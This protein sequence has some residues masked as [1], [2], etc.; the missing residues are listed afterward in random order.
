[1]ATGI[2]LLDEASC[3]VENFYSCGRT[4]LSIFF[5][6][7]SGV[8]GC[9]M[10]PW[11]TAPLKCQAELS[12]ILLV[13]WAFAIA[14]LTFG[15]GPAV[16]IN[17]MYLGIF[18][19]F[20]LS[21]N[22][23]STTLYADS[24]LDAS[25]HSQVEF[26]RRES[27]AENEFLGAA[28]ILD[29]A[30]ANITRVSTDEDPNNDPRRFDES[31]AILFESVGGSISSLDNQLTSPR[32][33]AAS[34]FNRKVV[35]GKREF[36]RVEIWF[37]LFV[38]SS[39]CLS[40]FVDEINSCESLVRQW[41]VVTP[42]LSVLISL[43]GWFTS[44]IKK[45]W[46]YYSEGALILIC[47]LFWM[48]GLVAVTRYYLNAEIMTDECAQD[49]AG[50][51]RL[52]AN[53]LF[54]SY[55]SFFTSLYLM[56]EW[57]DASTTTTDWIFLTAASGTIFGV[58]YIG[59]PD[60]F[61]RCNVD[62]F[63]SGTTV[64]DVCT[65]LEIKLVVALSLGSALI[66]FVMVLVSFISCC[67]VKLVPIVH[68]IIGFTLLSLWC[69]GSYFIVFEQEGVGSEI[70]P[71]FFNC[72][73]SLFFCV[74]IATTNL[75]LVFR[76]ETGEHDDESLGSLQEGLENYEDEEGNTDTNNA[77][78][79]KFF[80]ERPVGANSPLSII[81]DGSSSRIEYSDHSAPEVQRNISFEST[82]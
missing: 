5:G 50:E 20:F 38:Q 8:A 61:R 54:M 37:W 31:T 58:L 62:N 63:D 15:D 36:S 19:C 70:G 13:T 64:N 53:Q 30:Y 78:R 71:T 42:A 34:V 18:F 32:S 1:M 25:P 65:D 52:T 81:I 14:I 26:G 73:L 2:S 56:T 80:D 59:H 77:V 22:I 43:I 28:G 72:W 17:T 47:I 55:G 4:F 41:I 10:I 66:S 16:F 12:L 44:S 45:K 51:R 39:V 49:Y 11:R 9:L 46:A 33:Q 82:D 23:F 74:D 57:S 7:F 60:V 40:V 21:V 69:V 29:M 48:Q 27:Q 6:L 35:V 79:G 75:I 3:N 68:V 76:G 67:C 24:I